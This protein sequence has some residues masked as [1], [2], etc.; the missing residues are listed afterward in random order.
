MSLVESFAG[1]TSSWEI[2]GWEALPVST[3]RGRRVCRGWELGTS[4]GLQ[5]GFLEEVMAAVLWEEWAPCRPRM[6]GDDGTRRPGASVRTQRR[7]SPEYLHASCREFQQGW[8]PWRD[9]PG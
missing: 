1:L 9:H 8:F 7:P 2:A 5:E 6:G 4:W 3:V